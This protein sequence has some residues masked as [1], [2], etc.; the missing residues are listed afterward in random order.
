MV[1]GNSV[2]HLI[3]RRVQ[4]GNFDDYEMVRRRHAGHRNCAGAER[5]VMG[6]WR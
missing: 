3:E 2:A 5:R 1:V 4:Q 6:R